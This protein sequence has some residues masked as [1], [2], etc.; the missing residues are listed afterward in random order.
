MVPMPAVQLR[1]H[2]GAVSVTARAVGLPRRSDGGEQAAR[3]LA[4]HTRSQITRATT[5]LIDIRQTHLTEY[6]ND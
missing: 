5:A 2:E 6:H 3:V 4:A 1:V